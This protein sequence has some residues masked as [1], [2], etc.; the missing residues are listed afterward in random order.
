MWKTQPDMYMR[1]GNVTVRLIMGRDG[2]D[3]VPRAAKVM[4]RQSSHTHSVIARIVILYTVYA[5]N[6]IVQC[7]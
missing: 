2:H 1:S 7:L 6:L 4:S 5:L 3:L